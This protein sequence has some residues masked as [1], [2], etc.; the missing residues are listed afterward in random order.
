MKSFLI[1]LLI[2]ISQIIYASEQYPDLIIYNGNGYEFYSYPMET[3]FEIYPN[4][5]PSRRNINSALLRGY[6]ATYE[7]IN[8]ELILINIETMK[9]NGNWIQINNRHFRNNIKINTFSGK[10]HLCNGESTGIYIGF[11]PIFENYIVL[12]IID[13]T[14]VDF[15]EINCIEYLESLIQLSSED[16]YSYW[17]YTRIL[18]SLNELKGM[19]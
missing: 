2:I 8:N 12:S 9:F 3:Y 1:G 13:G 17:Y 14:V 11:T 7:I 6:R 16:S 5:R 19:N 15:F 4:R 10:I 18:N